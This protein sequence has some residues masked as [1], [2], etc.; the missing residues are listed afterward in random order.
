MNANT[1]Q[2]K[3]VCTTRELADEI[4]ACALIGHRQ[5]ALF[6]LEGRVYAIDNHD[7]F[8]G[9]NV[10]A[11][12][13]VGDLKGRTVVAS[14]IYKHHFDLETGQCLEDS[15]VV[16]TTYAARMQGDAIEIAC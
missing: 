3:K 8:S 14:P 1:L 6:M 4:G 10:I 16:L 7:P 15:S 9:A 2:W 11:R 12:G 13:L 5:V